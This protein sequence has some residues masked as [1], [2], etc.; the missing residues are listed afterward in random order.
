VPALAPRALALRALALRALA[1]RAL[2]LRALALRAL[3]VLAPRGRRRAPA[4]T[5]RPA[6]TR[7]W[8]RRGTC[9][10]WIA[11]ASR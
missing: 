5:T 9:G 1:L 11:P 8:R 3:P 10:R 7:S 4:A 2:A 6:M